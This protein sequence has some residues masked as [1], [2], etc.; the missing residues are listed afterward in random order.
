MELGHTALFSLYAL[1]T[2]VSPGLYA[3]GA[4]ADYDEKRSESLGMEIVKA[5]AEQLEGTL[6]QRNDNGAEF[7]IAFAE[8]QS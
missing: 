4:I 8:I 5:L 3:T 6:E 1:L 2:L 7:K